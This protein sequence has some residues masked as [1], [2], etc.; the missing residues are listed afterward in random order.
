VDGL[1]AIRSRTYQVEAS[2]CTKPQVWLRLRIV[3]S[4]AL[5]SS[6]SGNTPKPAEGEGWAQQAHCGG[7]LGGVASGTAAAGRPCGRWPETRIQIELAIIT[8]ERL[9]AGSGGNRRGR[10][11]AWMAGVDKKAT[12]A[13]AVPGKK[14]TVSAAARKRMPDATKKRWAA[15]KAQTSEAESNT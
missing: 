14:R 2:D 5:V 10:P 6:T 8:I 15:K 3:R 11:P 13:G 12:V 7:L 9:A 1:E 4:A